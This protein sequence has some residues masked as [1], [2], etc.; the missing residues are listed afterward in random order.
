MRCDALERGQ[1]IV[2]ADARDSRKTIKNPVLPLIVEMK[3]KPTIL[4]IPLGKEGAGSKGE[5][6]KRG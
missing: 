3:A 4:N 2:S 6:K 1:K 5:V